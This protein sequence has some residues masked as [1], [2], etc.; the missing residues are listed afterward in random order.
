MAEQIPLIAT[1]KQSL[2]LLLENIRYDLTVKLCNGIMAVTV[3][4]DGV[5]VIENRRAV[6]SVP[7]IPG[8]PREFGN[9]IFITQD[10]DLPYWDKFGGS[11]QFFYL[12]VAE[13]EA[14]RDG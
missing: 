14:M 7:V 1:E 12:T 3:I 5:T 4:R 13:M 9:F 11:Q 10:D 6:A 2:S 8:G